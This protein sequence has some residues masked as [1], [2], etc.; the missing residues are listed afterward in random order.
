MSAYEEDNYD[1]IKP[2]TYRVDLEYSKELHDA[3]N[4]YP[5]AVESLTVDGVKKLIPNLNDKVRYVVHHEPLKFYLKHGMVLKKVHEGITYTEKAFMRKFIDICT[6]A[7]KNAKNDFEKDIFKLGP[8]SC[9]GKTL[10]NLRNRMDVEIVNDNDESDRK[11][12]YKT[13]CK[14]KL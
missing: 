6:E 13:Y 10:E 5:L 3:H 1:R 11:K 4:A 8:N 9:F 14:A 12:T 7:R 2:G